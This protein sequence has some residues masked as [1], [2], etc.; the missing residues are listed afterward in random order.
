MKKMLTILLLA[1]PIGVVAEEGAT[2]KHGVSPK[3]FY[4]S[5]YEEGYDY[6][7]RG[8]GWEYS[9]SHPE[10]MN[11]KISGLTNA[12]SKDSFSESN[13]SFFFKFPVDE[14]HYLYPV[15]SVKSFKKD[16]KKSDDEEF[17]IYKVTNFLGMGWEKSINQ[18][19]LFNIE[20]SLSHDSLN[21]ITWK[22]PKNYSSRT[23]SCPYGF[24]AKAGVSCRCKDHLFFDADGYYTQTF[25]K[26]YK[27]VG[28][29]I[30]CKVVF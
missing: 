6:T 12:R 9:F 8:G 11:F 18:Y 15:F 1:A 25:K 4:R 22:R 10:G 28:L 7:V 17:S 20:G 24:R 23:F 2:Y 14:D 21:M 26:E 5:Y 16:M 13:M 19:F 3:L 27:T 30:S 29:E